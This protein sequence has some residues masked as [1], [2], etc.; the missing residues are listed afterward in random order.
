MNVGIILEYFQCV[1]QFS[2][3]Y[4]RTKSAIKSKYIQVS[5]DLHGFIVFS[6]AK[7]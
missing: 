7:A 3:I 5:V 6:V 2:T 1:R 4:Q